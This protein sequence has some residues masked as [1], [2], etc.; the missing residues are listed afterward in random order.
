VIGLHFFLA[1][2]VMTLR[3]RARAKH[4][5]D[6]VLRLRWIWRPRFTDRS[7]GRRCPG[8]GRQPH[9][10]CAPE[11]ANKL[12]QQGFDAVGNVDAALNAFGFKMGPVPD[13][14]PCVWIYR[15]VLKGPRLK[16]PYP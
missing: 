8:F 3:H 14:R 16:N 7:A 4:T 12:L 2:N 15:V 10:V 1:A 9:F 11:T 13:V 5:A 6:D